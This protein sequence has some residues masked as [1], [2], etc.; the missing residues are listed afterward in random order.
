MTMIVI[1]LLCRCAREIYYP[2]VAC[3][4]HARQVT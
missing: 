3:S 1:D 2:W 4:I